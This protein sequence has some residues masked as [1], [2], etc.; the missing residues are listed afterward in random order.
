MC[1]IF[2]F[3]FFLGIFDLTN[4]AHVTKSFDTPNLLFFKHYLMFKLNNKENLR[5]FLCNLANY[6]ENR[7]S[8]CYKSV[9]F[10]VIISVRF[11]F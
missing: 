1:L 10:K 11:Y 6:K 7:L 4:L 5:D 3:C 2:V 9:F 8:F